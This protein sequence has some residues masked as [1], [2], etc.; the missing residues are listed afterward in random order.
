MGGG[1]PSRAM[2]GSMR[3]S[4]APVALGWCACC[5]CKDAGAAVVF[6]L[7]LLR[8]V[9]KWRPAFLMCFPQSR[10]A[11]RAANGLT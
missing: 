1:E 7:N 5:S 6:N 10:R 9:Y 4:I 2:G 3:A 8:L 11:L